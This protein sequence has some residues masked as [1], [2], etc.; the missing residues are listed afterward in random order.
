MS[1]LAI[2]DI[3]E[4]IIDGK[5]ESVGFTV[6]GFSSHAQLDALIVWHCER[7]KAAAIMTWPECLIMDEIAYEKRI[8]NWFQHYRFH[9]RGVGESEPSLHLPAHQ[10]GSLGPLWDQIAECGF[11][12]DTI[13]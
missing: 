2:T 5:V 9:G 1:E 13:K 12:A 3:R 8:A 4:R 10:A 11:P 6:E 7:S